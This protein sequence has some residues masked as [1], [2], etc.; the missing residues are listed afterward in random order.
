MK[1]A[2][3]R[4]RALAWYRHV[5]PHYDRSAERAE[6]LLGRI[7]LRPLRN[8]LIA[9]LRLQPGDVVVDVGCGTGL[10]FP[11]LEA[12]IG[13]GGRLLGVELSPDMLAKARERVAVNGWK[14][15][16]LIQAPAEEA[17]LPLQ[18]DA[19]LFC[20]GHDIISSPKAIANMLGQVKRGARVV[21]GG[22]KWAP[23]WAV[24]VN[25]VV[26][27]LAHGGVTTF[28]GFGRPW[29][30]LA[31]FVPDLQVESV[32]GGGAYVAWGALPAGER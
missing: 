29:R 26:W 23:W 16:T 8:R 21:A 20:L 6:R 28:E 18:A 32:A 1:G 17:R 10:S 25:L 2:P 14:N 4:Q 22:T 11:L 31:G 12:G 9:H 3:D 27:S 13:P 7:G 15:V 30:H 5:A 19:V 24:P